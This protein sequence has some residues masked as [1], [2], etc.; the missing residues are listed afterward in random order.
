[1]TFLS[2]L[3]NKYVYRTLTIAVAL[4]LLWF[5]FRGVNFNE[6][7][8]TLSEAKPFYILLSFFALAAGSALR[9]ARWW[10]LMS[11]EGSVPLK[12]A[13]WASMAGQMV[14]SFVPARGGDLF[15]AAYIGH[16]AQISKMFAL[17]TTLLERITD[18]AVITALG[19]IAISRLPAIAPWLRWGTIIVALCSLAGILGIVAAVRLRLPLAKLMERLPIP[20]RFRDRITESLPKFIV[21]LQ[22]MLN[23]TRATTFIAVTCCV[24]LLDAS[25]AILWAMGLDLQ[26]GL[27]QALL[28]NFVLA[29]TQIAPTT[30][31]GLGVNQVLALAVLTPMGF[32]QAQTLAF[33]LSSQ[34]FFLAVIALLGFAAM[35][36]IKMG[37]GQEKS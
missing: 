21:G 13:L 8:A 29:L 24:W 2:G 4:G 31:G 11:A 35:V 27:M 5:A 14:N 25:Y 26:L 37:N 34:A 19:M 32:T 10:I 3:K 23:P 6:L 28:L 33:I 7:I 16:D 1:M 12:S 17:G 36:R 15:R 9:G 22:G 20:I 18:M 30:P